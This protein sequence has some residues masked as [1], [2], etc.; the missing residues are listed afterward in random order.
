MA[1]QALVASLRASD[2]FLKIAALDSLARL[3]ARLPWTLFEPFAADRCSGATPSRRRPVRASPTPCARWRRPRA[4]PRRPSPARPSSRSGDL[5]TSAGRGRRRSSTWRGTSCARRPRVRGTHGDRPLDAEDSRARGGA[6]AAPGA[7]ARRR[8]R[9]GARRGPGR[10]R[11]GRAGRSRRCGSSD[12]RWWDRSWLR[13][14]SRARTSGSP[15]SALVATLEGANLATVRVA[16][17]HGLEDRRSTSSPAP[18]RLWGRVGDAQDL[19]ACRPGRPRRSRG[20]PRRRPTPSPRSRRDTSTPPARC[21]ARRD[22][23][24]DPLALGCVLLRRHRVDA[25]RSTRRREAPERALAH[26]DARGAPRGD[27]RARAGRR[28]VGG[29]CG[30]L[31]ARRR[32]ARGEARRGARPRPPR[33]RRAPRRGRRPHARSRAHRNG[34]ARARRG[35]RGAR[36]GG[37]ASP[38]H[39]RRRGHRVRRASRPSGTS[40]RRDCR[41]TWRRRAKTRSSPR[42]ITRTPRS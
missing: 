42:S 11:R 37:G 10:G 3:E 25:S 13:R 22:P 5:V 32:R 19:D 8:R 33:S 2:P 9:A 31:R 30:R 38:G 41:R 28:R 27:R 36:P 4:T 12:L 20:S 24:A 26:D 39:A 14:R 34:S 7:A 35:R 16:L 29:R 6:L 17:R 23:G 40:R 15:P 1:T 21:C 18:S